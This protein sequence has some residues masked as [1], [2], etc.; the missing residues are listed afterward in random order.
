[1]KKGLWTCLGVGVTLAALGWTSAVRAQSEPADPWTRVPA[2]PTGCYYDAGA[3]D[4]FNKADAALQAEDARQ[5]KINDDLTQQFNQMDPMAKAQRMQAFMMK[6]P[7][8]AAAMVQAMQ[9]NAGTATSQVKTSM[10]E[11]QKLDQDLEALHA[12]FKGEVGALL[13]PINDKADAFFKAHSQPGEAGPYIPN[14]ADEAQY[15]RI[16]AERNTAYEKVCAGYWGP[17]GLVQSWLGK[18]KALRVNEAKSYATNDD[19]ILL[20]MQ[21]LESPSG[22]YRSTY[23]L[24]A[25][26]KYTAKVISILEQ[27]PDKESVSTGWMR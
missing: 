22:G 17:G 25:A 9:G 21:I 26:Q 12:K 14:K 4:L 11:D 3:Q 6:D 18:Y 8:K 2:L 24:E 5:K 23:A 7:Q 15:N 19:T 16:L 1:M 13:K 27:R 10:A 20:Q